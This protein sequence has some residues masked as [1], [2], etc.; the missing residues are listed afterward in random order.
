MS[1]VD[2]PCY[3]AGAT[4]NVS[5][6]F[7]RVVDQDVPV[8]C[9]SVAVFP[10]DVLVGDDDGVIV[11]PRALAD[12]VAEGGDTQERLEEFIG[13][14]VR[15]GTSLRTA[16]LGLATLASERIRVP[17]LA[18]AIALECRLHSA[19]RYGRTGAEFLVGE[20]L[21]FHIRDGLAVEGK[22]ETERLAPIARLAGP[23][24]AALGTITR[25]Q[26]LE[27]TPESVL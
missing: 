11:I 24:Y 21:L 6:A 12:D 13:A 9:G 26:P 2:L 3:S 10:G 8:G 23:A 27:Q 22:I 15:A 20:V 25:L 1:A 7:L 16:V 18:P 19:T 4:A 17:R 5:R 14:E